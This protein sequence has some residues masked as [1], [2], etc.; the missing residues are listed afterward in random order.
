LQWRRPDVA[1]TTVRIGVIA[2]RS[3]ADELK[4]SGDHLERLNH[5]TP[6][7]GQRHDEANMASI[8]R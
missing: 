5:L 6:A 4:L 3:A 7:A 1:T 2:L 8:D